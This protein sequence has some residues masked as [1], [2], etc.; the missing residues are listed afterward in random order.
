MSPIKVIGTASDPLFAI[1]LEAAERIEPLDHIS[2]L[3][4]AA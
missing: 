1:R 3:I 2:R 4:L